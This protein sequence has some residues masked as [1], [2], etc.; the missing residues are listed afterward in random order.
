MK[1]TFYELTSR[2]FTASEEATAMQTIQPTHPNLLSTALTRPRR[3]TL[4]AVTIASVALLAAGCGSSSPGG[5]NTGSPASFTTAAFKFASCMRD[6]GLSSFPDPSMT[7]HDGQQV[8]Y[9][10]TPDS[11]MAS[12]AFKVANTVC[13]KILTPYI[14]TTPNLAA[15]A[16]REQHL[17]A[18]AKCMRSHGVPS[19]PDPTN[20]GQLTQQMITN[21][22]VDLTAPAVLAAAKACLP[23]AGGAISAQQLQSAV[24]GTQ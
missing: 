2:H 9:L 22:G 13:Q 3:A 10:P 24:G 18:F 14:D 1:A 15:Q 23:A 12:P 11:L 8:A 17:A 5:P 7:D 16:T 20:Q 21:A 19:F 6:H 4:L